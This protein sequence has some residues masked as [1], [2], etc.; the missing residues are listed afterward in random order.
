MLFYN[1]LNFRAILSTAVNVFIFARGK[2][3]EN[4]D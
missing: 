3:C 2:F 4:V 1:H